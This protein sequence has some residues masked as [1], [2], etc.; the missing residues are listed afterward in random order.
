MGERREVQ[1]ER[2]AEEKSSVQ[3]EKKSKETGS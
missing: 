1:E 2:Q 3:H